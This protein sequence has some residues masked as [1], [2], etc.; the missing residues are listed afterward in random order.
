M[1]AP[2]RLPFVFASVDVEAAH[3]S[4]PFQQMI[5]GRTDGG[6]YWGVFQIAEILEEF[7][8]TATFFVDV[9][10]DVLWG[11]SAMKKLCSVPRQHSIDRSAA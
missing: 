2:F 10:E 8:Y 1:T 11:S 6:E 9:H 3:G 4:E 7:G 5:L